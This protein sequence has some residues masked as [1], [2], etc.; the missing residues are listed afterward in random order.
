MN[1]HTASRSL[2]MNSLTSMIACHRGSPGWVAQSSLKNAESNRHEVSFCSMSSVAELLSMSQDMNSFT[3]PDGSCYASF[4]IDG[5]QQTHQIG[6]RPF[7]SY[8]VRVYFQKHGKPPTDL[9][10]RMIIMR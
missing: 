5:R 3:S 4:Q 6:T 9:L 8:L 1:A 2:R 7:E 10:D